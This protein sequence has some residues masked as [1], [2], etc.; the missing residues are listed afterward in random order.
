MNVAKGPLEKFVSTEV[1]FLLKDIQKGK[2]P[3]ISLEREVTDH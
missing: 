1:L 2:Q 3:L